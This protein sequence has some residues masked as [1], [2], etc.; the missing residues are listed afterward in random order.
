MAPKEYAYG[1]PKK[2]KA[3]RH[4]DL[5]ERRQKLFEDLEKVEADLQKQR[6]LEESETAALMSQWT[7]STKQ[8]HEKVEQ[9]MAGKLKKVAEEEEVRR[10]SVTTSTT[11]G[12]RA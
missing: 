5:K 4:T 9:H 8:R 11:Q 10:R 3:E 1:P 6:E 7:P 2:S 12:K